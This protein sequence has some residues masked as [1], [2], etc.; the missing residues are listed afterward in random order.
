M[1][2]MAWD[3]PQWIP[4]TEEIQTRN[5]RLFALANSV[6]VT[7]DWIGDIILDL[8]NQEFR[9]KKEVMGLLAQLWMMRRR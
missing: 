7:K 9:H 4:T 6:S 1:I 3:G 8:E 2:Y 5:D